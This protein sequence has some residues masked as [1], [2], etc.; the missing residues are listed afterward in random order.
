MDLNVSRCRKQLHRSS[1]KLNC[2]PV[3]FLTVPQDLSSVA[4]FA[5]AYDQPAIDVLICNA[6]IMNT[7]FALSKASS[8]RSLSVSA[9]SSYARRGVSQDGIEQQ[10]Q[11]NHLGHFKLVRQPP[12]PAPFVICA[13]KHAFSAISLIAVQIHHLLPKLRAAGSARV[14]S[15]SSRAHMRHQEAIDYKRLK[16]ETAESYDGWVAYG[17]SKLSQILMSKVR[18][19]LSVLCKRAAT[20]RVSCRPLTVALGSGGALPAVDRR[21]LLRQPPWPRRHWCPPA[22]RHMFPPHLACF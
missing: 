18:P 14:V 17:R 11:S 2:N 8:A 7:P 21:L 15:L 10:Y 22:K 6:G 9:R 3:L 13:P 4:S 12:C 16:N 1:L 19:P 20:V 5:A